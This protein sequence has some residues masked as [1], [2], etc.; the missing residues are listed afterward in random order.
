MT[1]KATAYTVRNDDY[2]E[3]RYRIVDVE[4]GE[5]LDDAQGYGYKT[6][7]KAYAGYGYK[8]KNHSKPTA[9]RWLNKHSDLKED[10]L[11]A[12]FQLA[13]YD[14]NAKLDL[15]TIEDLLKKHKLESEISSKELLTYWN[16]KN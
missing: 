13:K 10:L 15:D 7:R 14:E 11:D 2:P 9:E 6:A 3:T 8:N 1:I 4:T 12:T 5:I 16:A